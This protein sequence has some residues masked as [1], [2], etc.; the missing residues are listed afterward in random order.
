MCCVCNYVCTHKYLKEKT[1][2]A[3][4]KLEYCGRK[5]KKKANEQ[6][7]LLNNCENIIRIC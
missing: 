4:A 6:Y 7:K 3:Q 2:R 5:K 1:K